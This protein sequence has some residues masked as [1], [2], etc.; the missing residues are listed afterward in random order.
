MFGLKGWS[1]R[2]AFEV[3]PAS[4]LCRSPPRASVPCGFRAPIRMASNFLCL[5]GVV[6][7]VPDSSRS[8]LVAGLKS[9]KSAVSTGSDPSS[10]CFTRVGVGCSSSGPARF[11]F[12]TALSDTTTGMSEEGSRLIASSAGMS[13]LGGNSGRG[14]SEVSRLSSDES[15][16]VGQVPCGSSPVVLPG[17]DDGSCGSLDPLCSGNPVEVP[18]WTPS[19]ALRVCL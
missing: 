2:E 11:L 17:G 14:M 13:S 15:L 9:H 4:S 6:T 10:S 1:A 16:C 3:C 12:R 8:T 7:I 5:R 19:A 18:S